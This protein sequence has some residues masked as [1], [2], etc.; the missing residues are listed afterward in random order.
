M[1]EGHNGAPQALAKAPTGVSGLDEITE[2][3][4]PRGRS[5][6]VTG[7]AGCGKT[8]LAMEFLVRGA[9]DYG[10]PG[11]FMAFEEN[12]Q[13]LA[14]NVRSLGFDLDEMA[15]RKEILIDAVQIERSEIEESGEYD[16]E[17]L[18]VRLNHAI[19]TIGAKRVVLDTIEVLFGSLSDSI[20]RSELRRLFR[21]LSQKGVTA[22]ITAERGD[23][24]L[25]RHGL[26]EYISDCVVLLDHRVSDQVLTRRLRVVKYRGSSHGTNEY[27]FFIDSRGV[28]VLPITS[29]GLN[30]PASDERISSGIAALDAMLGGRGYYRG[31]SVLIS[32]TAGSGKSSVAAHFVKAACARGEPA[33]YLAFEESP[34]QIQ[35]NMRSIGID[36]ERWVARGLL[37]FHAA[38]PTAHG[39]E[40]HLGIIF[41]LIDETQP[42]AVVVDPITN[43]N[44]VGT[45][46][47]VKAAVTR[48]I[49]FLKMK[50]VT[51]LFTSLT[52]G[53]DNAEQ[54]AVGVSSLMDTWLLLQNLELNGERNRGLYV[55][56]SR[57]MAHS[58]QVREFILTSKGVDLVD[59]YTGPA[60]VLTGTSRTIQEAKDETEA[61]RRAAEIERLERELQRKRASHAA[62]AT[63][64]REEFAAQEQ[65]LLRELAELRRDAA[66]VSD[67]LAKAARLRGV[68]GDHAAHESSGRETDRG[69]HA[70]RRQ[71]S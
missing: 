56:K 18:F 15:R 62:R 54:T 36:L 41:H 53:G 19:D 20:L 23:G 45:G 6:L 13:E 60:G 66:G 25:T 49:D 14:E 40:M 5:T 71:R 44:T 11:V 59:V 51:A 31:S 16:L 17:G 47:E 7:A 58:N 8:V 33:V 70:E 63:A 4:L 32:G 57:G 21:W 28:T 3:G 22:I 50:G 48:L 52:G 67:S 24:S 10:E 9:L 34:G 43:L 61:R 37:H 55:L 69:S 65:E 12:A 30:H 26:E 29:I 46:G 1:A 64:E 27:P 35:R 68:N 42:K 38:R 2:G 39:L